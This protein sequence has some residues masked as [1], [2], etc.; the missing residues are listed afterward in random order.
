MFL[1]IVLALLLML[2][3][4]VTN[5]TVDV[6]CNYGKPTVSK[7][8]ELKNVVKQKNCRPMVANKGVAL[9]N[10]DDSWCQ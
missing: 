8:T 6:A 2:L 3:L 7:D 9:K 5:Y 1:L 4:K 10:S